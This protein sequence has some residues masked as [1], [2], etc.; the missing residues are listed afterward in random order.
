MN[1]SSVSIHTSGQANSVDKTTTV[2]Y[3]G[4]RYDQVQTTKASIVQT[5]EQQ[6]RREERKKMIKR[7]NERLRMLDA[8][9]KER[10]LKLQ[11]DLQRLEAEKTAERLR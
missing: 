11:Q 9:S 5:G 1:S 2:R 4:K 6:E 8:M 3:R 10:Q 7:S